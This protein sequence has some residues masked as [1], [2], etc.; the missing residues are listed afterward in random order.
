[1]KIKKYVVLHKLIHLISKSFEQQGLWKSYSRSY[2]TIALVSLSIHPI[3][4]SQ[5]TQPEPQQLTWA[6]QE[7]S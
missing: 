1:M 4:N 7:F 3:R 5:F 2:N 6:T